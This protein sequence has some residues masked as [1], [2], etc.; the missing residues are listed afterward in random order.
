MAGRSASVPSPFT[1]IRLILLLV[2]GVAM[3]S[4]SDSK[5]DIGKEWEKELRL[6]RDVVPI[7]YDLLLHPHLH[8][9]TF[10]GEVNIVV[11]T[12]KPT[13][14]LWLHVKHLNVIATKIYRGKVARGSE[15]DKE[16]LEV[17]EAFEYPLHEF[18]V[19]KTKEEIPPGVYTLA[20][21]FTGS[22]KNGIKGF[23]ASSY[24]D[25]LGNTR[26]LATSK[27]QPTHARWTFPCFDEPSFKSTFKVALVRPSSKYS[28][29]SN[30][31]QLSE[32]EGVPM[33]GFTTVHFNESVPMVTYLA[34]FIV[35]DFAHLQGQLH[36]ETGQVVRVFAPENKIEDGRYAL[37]IGI[38]ITRYFEEYFDIPFP[39]PK[40]DH[41]AIPDFLGGAMEHWALITYREP[42]LLYNPE[43]SSMGD[44]QRV[45]TIVSHELAHHWFGNL[46]TLEWWDDLWLNEGFASYI[47]YKGVAQYETD[48]DMDTVFLADDLQ[49]ILRQDAGLTSHPIVQVVNNPDE[50]TEL[51]DSITYAKV[52]ASL[53]RMLEFFMGPEDFRLG[54][55]RFLK[56]FAYKNA[57]TSDLWN[58]LTQEWKRKEDGLNLS[59]IMDTWTR[60]MGYPT[61]NVRD[62]GDHYVITQERFIL[63]PN[64]TF[65]P[66]E[67]PFMYRWE[68]PLNY[69]TSIEDHEDEILWLHL[70]DESLKIEKPEGCEWIKL[71]V[72]QKGYY[73]VNYP[74]D[75][76]RRFA[77]L[78]VDNHTALSAG[79]RSNLVDDAF[80]L[81]EAGKLSYEIPLHM[82]KYLKYESHYVP[83]R[84]A[85]VNFADISSKTYTL[86]FFGDLRSYLSRLAE[87]IL[88]E[89]GWDVREEE[90]LIKRLLRSHG[91][92]LACR[93]G[94]KGCLEE[95]SKRLKAWITNPEES[96]HPD[97]EKAIFRYGMM[98]AGDQKTWDALWTRYLQEENSQKQRRLLYGLGFTREPW[99]LHRYL[100]YL[101]NTSLVRDH[102]FLPTLQSL[103]L[104]PVATGIV[105]DFF[106]SEWNYLVGRFTLNERILGRTVPV[107]TQD[108]ITPFQ[109]KSMERFFADNPEAGAGARARETAMES[110]RN[111]I[112]WVRSH[113]PVEK[114]RIWGYSLFS[115][116]F[117]GIVV[118]STERM[119]Q[120]DFLDGTTDRRG[121]GWH[122]NYNYYNQQAGGYGYGHG[123]NPYGSY[124]AGGYPG[125]YVEIKDLGRLLNI[126]V[127]VLPA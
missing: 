44:K 121:F 118:E 22:L 85:Y 81:A 101:K 49:R 111:N 45:A 70:S 110:V 9:D 97:I 73:R 6:P 18:W 108:F 116:A 80:A 31:N 12:T 1:S 10:Y 35:S 107:I 87:P 62:D 2:V 8:N 103:C 106:R 72:N 90:G 33:D 51:F 95:A 52:G 93:N 100:H 79:D 78:L 76:W 127:A 48:W 94:H 40:L 53:L 37:D 105:W 69:K 26:K 68:V 28:A 57:V 88:N 74:E 77:E 38:N 114:M 83:W 41:I 120:E 64:D 125:G 19:L 63:N 112:H 4:E 102:D 59:L 91:I 67:S 50:I 109:L 115:L 25:S 99:L 3:G 30:M 96:I 16:S 55:S 66:N 123:Y 5:I 54:I 86:P 92:H 36:E 23:Y 89:L 11:K 126:C 61:L 84:A 119:A 7:H 104:N 56:R 60:Q 14:H 82:T 27:F 98:E 20:F 122:N 24:R 71:N 113:A 65:D 47:E 58:D 13:S 39:L 46:M 21:E 17:E 43:T 32:E 42:F 117:I 124:G 75:M 15:T 34:C 29:L